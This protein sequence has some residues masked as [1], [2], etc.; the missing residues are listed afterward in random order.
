[1]TTAQIFCKE[2]CTLIIPYL[3]LMENLIHQSKYIYGLSSYILKGYYSTDGLVVTE[4]GSGLVN[5]LGFSGNSP[6]WRGPHSFK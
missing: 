3:S 5:A 2:I 6:N 1:M 4:V